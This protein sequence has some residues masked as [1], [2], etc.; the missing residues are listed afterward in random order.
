LFCGR[1]IEP[2]KQVG[3]AIEAFRRKRQRLVVDPG[4]YEPDKIR[5]H[6]PPW[7][8]GRFRERLVE[9]VAAAAGIRRENSR[10]SRQSPIAA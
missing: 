6:A 7:D 3:I 10:D 2:Y 9:R 8:S 4:A 5:E 1:L